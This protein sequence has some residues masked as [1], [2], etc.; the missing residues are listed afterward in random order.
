MNDDENE[1]DI[2]SGE[3]GGIR[4]GHCEKLVRIVFSCWQKCGYIE[5]GIFWVGIIHLK[6]ATT[7]FFE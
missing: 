4:V 1:Y 7:L 3:S 5:M 2:Q 6:S